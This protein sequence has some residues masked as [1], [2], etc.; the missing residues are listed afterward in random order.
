MK[1]PTPKTTIECIVSGCG[2]FD[3]IELVELQMYCPDD[4]W[5][6][7][8]GWEDGWTVNEDGGAV[9]PNHED[10]PEETLSASERN[11]FLTWRQH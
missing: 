9:C 4:V 2:F 1:Y 3:E 6:L 5:A 8:P 10:E 11:R 7:P